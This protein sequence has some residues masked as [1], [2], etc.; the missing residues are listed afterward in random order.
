MSPHFFLSTNL[1]V[2]CFLLSFGMLP[3]YFSEHVFSKPI[4]ENVFTP[5]PKRIKNHPFFHCF[6]INFHLL[7]RFSCN[8]LQFDYYYIS[9]YFYTQKKNK[10]NVLPFLYYCNSFLSAKERMPTHSLFHIITFNCFPFTIFIYPV[11]VNFT[12]YFSFRL[13]FHM[14]AVL[15]NVNF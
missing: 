3:L 15:P 9:W 4:C 8:R 6:S 14:I 10:I 12:N 5:A 11:S 1:F 7:S 13:I 2:E